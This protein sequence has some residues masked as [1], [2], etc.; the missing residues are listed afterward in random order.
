MPDA[1]DC[2]RCRCET[3][4]RGRALTQ[5]NC[6]AWETE[7]KERRVVHGRPAADADWRGGAQ[8]RKVEWK[9]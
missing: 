1:V 2:R 9:C 4:R 8:E 7:E 3:G 5:L 6:T